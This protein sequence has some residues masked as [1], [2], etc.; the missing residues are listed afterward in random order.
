MINKHRNKKT[1]RVINGKLYSFDSSK[2]ARRFDDLYLLAR[3]GKITDLELQ[4]KFKLMH[5]QTHNGIT[6]RS[7]S[8]IADFRYKKD[9]KTIVEDVKSEHSKTLPTYRVKVKW[10]L[11]LYGKHLIFLETWYKSR[12][13]KTE[14]DILTLLALSFSTFLSVILNV[15]KSIQ[16]RYANFTPSSYKLKSGRVCMFLEVLKLHL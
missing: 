3:S 12:N 4:P 14:Y 7:T 1:P 10:F 11:S 13:I 9:G 5:A 2:E 16:C 8:Y 6:Y 15:S